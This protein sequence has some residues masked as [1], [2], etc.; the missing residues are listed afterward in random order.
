MWEKADFREA[1]AREGGRKPGEE[2]IMEEVKG[3]PYL[4]GEDSTTVWGY[5]ELR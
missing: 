5:T 1:A 3:R 4:S 2:L